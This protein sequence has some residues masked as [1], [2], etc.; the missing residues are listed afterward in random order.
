MF[1]LLAVSADRYLAICHP[2]KYHV[3]GP[4]KTKIVICLCWA[5]GSFFGFLPTFGWNSGKFAD[6]CD[7]RVIA[8]F[9]YLLFICSA[10][11]FLST[12]VILVLYFLIYRAVMKQVNR[13]KSHCLQL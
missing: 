9:N 13:K 7:L 5:F 12:A 6:Q 10:I 8:D 4:R 1:S 2:L 11:S 3:K